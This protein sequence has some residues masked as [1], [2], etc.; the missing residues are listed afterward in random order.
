MKRSAVSLFLIGVLLAVAAFV[1]D[2][3]DNIPLMIDLLAPRY[4]E[5]AAALNTLQTKL[6]LSPGDKGFDVVKEVF[7]SKLSAENPPEKLAG[8]EVTKVERKRPMI[9]FGMLRAGEVVPVIFSLSN[10]QTLDWNLDALSSEILKFKTSRL[11]RFS[12]LVLAGAIA[13]QTSAFFVQARE[14]RQK[15]E[16]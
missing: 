9:S 4:V 16:K 13:I 12:A 11:F 3:A 15:P 1:G 10:G 8:I 7:L 2:K 14:S 5:G 6:V